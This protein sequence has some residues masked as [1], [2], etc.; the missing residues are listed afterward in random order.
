MPRWCITNSISVLAM[1]ICRWWMWF[2]SSRNAA[3]RS[4]P[5]AG[6]I[7]DSTHQICVRI[8]VWALTPA[9]R[10][11]LEGPCGFQVIAT[12][13]ERA[14]FPRGE[15]SRQMLELQTRSLHTFSG[16]NVPGQLCSCY[17]N[18]TSKNRNKN[19]NN[20]RNKRT[21]FLTP[22]TQRMGLNKCKQ[23]PLRKRQIRGCRHIFFA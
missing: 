6:G 14:A 18:H 8:L 16:D 4:A 15:R 1:P 20:W 5:T 13:T 9:R 22:S 11:T 17:T 2:R 21:D 12:L 3:C 19:N 7:L 23:R 10:S